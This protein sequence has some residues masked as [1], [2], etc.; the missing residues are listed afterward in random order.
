MISR[1]KQIAIPPGAYKY[2]EYFILVRTDTGRKLSG[3]GRWAGGPFYT[4]YKH[5]Y[6]A[7]ATYRHSNKLSGAFNY[8]HNN[9]SLA[10]GRFKTN[11]LS[12]RINYGF[13]TSMFINSLI[14]Y[15]SDTH[16]WSSNVRFNI[17]HRPLSDIF[18]VYNERR[19]SITGNLV[20]RALIAKMTYMI[21]R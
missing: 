10:E 1:E 19:D 7:G 8:N 6:Q 15:N 21:S 9:I 3:N 12:T 16:Q 4:G 20:D 17:I 5:S 2:S 14:Q 18:I 13:S 11:L